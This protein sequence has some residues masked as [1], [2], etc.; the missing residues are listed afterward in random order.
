MLIFVPLDMH[1]RKQMVKIKS[2]H[3]GRKVGE[4]SGVSRQT[5]TTRLVKNRQ[6]IVGFKP[7]LKTRDP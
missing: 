4:L 6:M 7:G 1:A 5:E 2:V 3:D